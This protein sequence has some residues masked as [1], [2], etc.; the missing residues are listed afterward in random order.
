MRHTA[1]LLFLI[2]AC[3][4][5]QVAESAE[6][7]ADHCRKLYRLTDFDHAVEPGVMMPAAN[8]VAAHCRVRG[9]VN[10]AIRFEVTLPID[11]WN[12]RMMFSAVGGDAGMIGDTTSL[13]SKG[14]AMASTDTGHEV[15]EGHG[16]YDQPQ[17]TLDYAFRGVHLATLAAK[18]VIRSYYRDEIDYAYING[19]SNGGRSAVLEAVRF[20]DDYDGIIAGAPTF[21]FL[22]MVP[23]MI[24]VHRAQTLNPLTS[25]SLGLLDDASSAACDMIDGVADGVI[26]DPRKCTADVFNVDSLVC[27]DSATEDCLTPGQVATAKY[28][29]QDMVDANGKVLSPGVM[30]G[31]EAAGDWAFWML[32]NTQFVGQSII[33]LMGKMLSRIMRSEPGFNV[34]DF[35]PIVD[36]AVIANATS[37]LDVRSAD[38]RE[39][40]E[41]GGK[42]LMYQGWND[43]PLR[44]QRAIDYLAAVESTVGGAAKTRDFYRMFMV[45]GMSHCAGGPGAWQADYVTP[46]VTW[47]EQG[48]APDQIIAQHDENTATHLTPYQTRKSPGSFSR[49]LCVYPEIAE[50]RG[51]GDK[52]DAASFSC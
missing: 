22:E 33:S 12:R 26:S 19:C 34:E 38:L 49:P 40:Q 17:A 51:I 7:A 10:R 42:L 20:P 25:E 45:P 13:L 4:A 27:N 3:I 39:F 44:P 1:T 5:S 48:K 52:D 9:V 18:M 46:L 14:Y 21:Q 32:P 37:P 24:G 41:R 31:A 16:F 47:R 6:T 2:T 23:W 29:Y 11:N 8:G 50:Y 36:R 28:V 35:D 15:A 30:P 43:W